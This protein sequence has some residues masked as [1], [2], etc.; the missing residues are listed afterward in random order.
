M[1]SGGRVLRFPVPPRRDVVLAA[2]VKARGPG[3]YPSSGGGYWRL[4]LSCGHT[5]LLLK[6][7]NDIASAAPPKTAQCWRCRDSAP[8]L[9]RS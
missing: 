2:R 6:L 4:T 7:V 9:V 8:A 3:R 1:N 5:A